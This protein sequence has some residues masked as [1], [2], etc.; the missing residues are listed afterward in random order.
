MDIKLAE[1]HDIPEIIAVQKLAF[2]DVAKYYNNYRLGPLQVTIKDLEK[3]FT[4]YTYLKAV[5]KDDIVG[6]VRAK[7][8][9]DVCKIENLIV[10]PAH[11]NLGI[12]KKLIT[13]LEEKFRDCDKISLFTGKNTPKNMDFYQSLGYIVIS[14]KPETK[15]EPILV[16]MEKELSHS[17]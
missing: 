15:T 12:G 6:S 8:V 11:Q 10:H 16:T 4:E 17:K 13:S 7:K 5:I 9:K 14:E 1:M 2:Y 3:N